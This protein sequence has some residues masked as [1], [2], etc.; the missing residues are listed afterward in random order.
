WAGFPGIPVNSTAALPAQ[1]L[2]GNIN[3][4][5]I[6]NVITTQITPDLKFKANYRFYDY[7]NGTPEIKFADWVLADAVSAKAFF[8]PLAPVQSI[9][10]SYIKQNIGGELTWR[11]SPV[12]NVGVGYGLERYNWVRADVDATPENFGQASLDWKPTGWITARASVLAAARRYETYDYLGFVG[13]A[14]WPAG[15]AVTRYSTAYRQFM[16]DN[17]DRIRARASLAVV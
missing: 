5:L 7:D 14:Q 9:S 17:R 1:S 6:N 10:I 3:T 11:P 8:A 2:N 16:F 15:D 12:W 13:A 4:L